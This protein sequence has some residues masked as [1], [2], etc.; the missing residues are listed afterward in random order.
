MAAPYLD[1]VFEGL[2]PSY[3]RGIE[4][5]ATDTGIA[6]TGGRRVTLIA[7]REDPMHCAR[8]DEVAAVGAVVVLLDPFGKGPIAHAAAHGVGFA[9]MQ[10]EPEQVMAAVVAA[11][12][13]MTVIPSSLFASMVGHD[14][15]GRVTISEEEG[16]WL[17]RLA[18]GTTVVR[19]ADDFGYSERAMFR[20]LH[21]LYT[22]L[23]VSNRSEALITAQ[24]LGLIRH[25]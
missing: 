6:T 11:A 18:G 5:A 15:H 22:R 2:P 16:E 14:P 9:D 25:G 7:L 10:A 12:D 4:R 3:R 17:T 13:G 23:G 8:I 19:L 1:L 21:D 24:R 20:R